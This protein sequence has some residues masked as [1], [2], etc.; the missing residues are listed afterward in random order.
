[1]RKQI[2]KNRQQQ[3]VNFNIKKIQNKVIGDAEI[4]SLEHRV[5][6]ASTFLAAVISSVAVV[7]NTILELNIYLSLFVLFSIFANAL[8][9]YYARIKQRFYP[10]IWLFLFFIFIFFSVNWF[11]AAGAA[12]S[13]TYFYFVLLFLASVMIKPEH[14]PFFLLILI[15]NVLL[16]FAVEFFYPES[17]V[18]YVDRTSQFLDLTITFTYT[19]LAVFYV[20][21]TVM[22]T[23]NEKQLKIEAEKSLVQEK[24]LEIES[25]RDNLQQI[26]ISL[27]EQ[28]ELINK[29]KNQILEQQKVTT[30]SIKDASRIQRALLPLK[31]SLQL[32]FNQYFILNKPR[33]IVSGD[34]YWQTEKDDKVII[35]VADCTG[36]GIPGAFMSILGISFLKEVVSSFA[37][38]KISAAG[39][40]N[41]LRSQ[42]ILSLHQEWNLQSIKNSM[43]MALCVIDKNTKM[44]QFSGA[45][46]P[47]IIVRKSKIIRLKGDNMPIGIFVGAEKEFTNHEF[48]LQKGD[49]VYLASD[50]FADQ[51]GGKYK[52]KFL[53][54]KFRALLAQISTESIEKQAQ[55]LDE[56]F[57][58]WRGNCPQIDDV[59][60]FGFR[61]T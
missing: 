37:G 31:K 27:E 13:T 50:G 20:V 33:D 36:H 15:L 32:A 21:S 47:V 61:L 1:M 42:V 41:H 9:Y 46:N 55:I 45:R 8:F 60:I 35:T 5:L 17:V 18:Q 3:K 11:F 58:N 59:M 6:N 52:M 53:T 44:M 48:Q 14:Y 43:D 4:F 25:Q 22:K 23:Y 51:F 12:G 40:L 26:N 49:M 2:T 16:L 56:T 24:N 57:E 38:S 7:F 19:A 39:I 34:F 30:D 28:K 29:Q 54:T 10:I